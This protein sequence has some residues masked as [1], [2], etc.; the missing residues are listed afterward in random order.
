MTTIPWRSQLLLSGGGKDT[1]YAEDK[2]GPTNKVNILLKERLATIT[3][4]QEAIVYSYETGRRSAEDVFAAN[5]LLLTAR[6]ELRENREARNA[7]LDDAVKNAQNLERSVQTQYEA[8]DLPRVNVLKA[9][10]YRLESEIALE[11]ANSQ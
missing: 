7:V 6:L 8:A 3:S 11:R 4:Y 2:A 1:A 10:I 5:V 9:R